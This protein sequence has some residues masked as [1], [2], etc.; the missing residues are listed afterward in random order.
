M[1]LP[2]ASGELR[3]SALPALAEVLDPA[4]VT[5][6]LT[7]AWRLAEPAVTG[8]RVGRRAD[9]K[10]APGAACVVVYHVTVQRGAAPPEPGFGV[11]E[12]LPGG[13]VYRRLADDPALPSAGVAADAGHMAAR[14]RALPS[15]RGAAE[16]PL[17]AVPVR[18]KPGRTC[19]V[20]YDLGDTAT[21]GKVMAEGSER[22]AS[23]LRQ[24]ADADGPNVPPLLAV[25][26][27]LG[28]TV[29]AAVTGAADLTATLAAAQP[30]AR[31]EWLRRT[32]RAVAALHATSVT[33]APPVVRWRDDL[34]ELAGYRPLFRALAPELEPEL[35][36]ALT[37]LA[38]AAA[39]LPPGGERLGHGALRT[40]QLV[41]DRSPRLSLLDLDGVCRADPAR[42]LGNL[43]AY[44]GWRGIRRPQ[45]AAWTAAAAPLV[46]EGYASV[47]DPPDAP[48]LEL[49]QALTMLRIAGRRLRSLAVP[50]WDRLP[51][52]LRRALGAV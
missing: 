17:R 43:L 29:Q 19:V 34:E 51:E 23:I 48:R 8:V 21:F 10:Y 32:G 33:P 11:A 46:L 12:A 49:F 9:T 37:G 4:A 26:P 31:D 5:A 27:D 28:M 42:D 45:D 38:G 47:A 20:R 39:T 50:E 36:R 6:G 40:D 35:D 7:R 52:L 14:L 3:D 18:Y 41:A 15:L 13:T 16:E 2:R 24:L 44:L 1:G 22:Q 30:S 25:W